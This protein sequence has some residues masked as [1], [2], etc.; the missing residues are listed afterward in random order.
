MRNQFAAGL[1]MGIAGIPWR[2]TDSGGF[3]GVNP[4]D[5][6]FRELFVRWFEWGTF[7][8]VM[9]LH[10][11]REPRQPQFG[12]TGGAF[13]CSGAANEVWSYVEEVYSICKKY[14]EYRE[15]MRPYTRKLMEEAHEKGTP[16]MR[17]LFYM[18]PKD[19]ICWDV[20]D[21]YMYGPDVLVAPV[22]YAGQKNRSVY[23][24][25]GEEWAEVF[26]GKE[27]EGGL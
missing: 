16:V 9:C 19:T 26:T 18:Y 2:T 1:N 10:G 4:D 14:M 24:S 20:E 7:C 17:T 27:Y 8:P 3:H 25:K 23:L 5:P 22:L 12:T 21:E 15:Q 6:K 11:N 13:C